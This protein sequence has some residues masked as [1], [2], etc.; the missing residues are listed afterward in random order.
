M[1]TQLGGRKEVKTP[2]G[3]I[4][5]LTNDEVIEVKRLERWRDGLGQII[6]YGS[7]FPG[8]KKRLHLLLSEKDADLS[9]VFHCANH[10]GIEVS[11][12]LHPKRRTQKRKEDEQPETCSGIFTDFSRI[13]TGFELELL[14]YF[15]LLGFRLSARGSAGIKLDETDPDSIL[16]RELALRGARELAEGQATKFK[17]GVI[18]DYEFS[19]RLYHLLGLVSSPEEG[20]WVLYKVS[21]IIGTEQIVRAIS[22]WHEW[23][24]TGEH[25]GYLKRFLLKLDLYQPFLWGWSQAFI[26]LT[27][28]DGGMILHHFKRV[29]NDSSLD[30]NPEHAAP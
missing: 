13:L 20:L 19:L 18:G 16:N 30:P 9:E 17:E 26:D 3:R 8:R 12:E 1:A 15:T 2:A 29:F 5:V 28:L 11:F 6:S 21:Q 7:Y 22:P 25:K 4:D 14:G 23:H 10:A 24:K 27:L